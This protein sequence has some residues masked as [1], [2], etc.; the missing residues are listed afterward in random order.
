MWCG[1]VRRELSYG[2]FWAHLTG[3]NQIGD[4][5]YFGGADYG[6]GGIYSIIYSNDSG[7]AFPEICKDDHTFCS[8]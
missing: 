6:L 1:V 8:W 2:A 4:K 5:V 7:G 3:A